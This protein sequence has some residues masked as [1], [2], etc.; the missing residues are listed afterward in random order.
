MHSVLSPVLFAVYLLAGSGGGCFWHSLFVG[1]FYYANDIVLLA[2]CAS[3][4]KKLCWIF[5]RLM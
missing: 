5:A 2:P 4:L 3:V 1:A